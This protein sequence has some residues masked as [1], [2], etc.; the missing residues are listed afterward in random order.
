MRYVLVRGLALF[1]MLSLVAC[2]GDGGA[3]ATTGD[4]ASDEGVDVAGPDGGDG[5]EGDGANEEA[6]GGSTTASTGGIGDDTAADT[7]A[8]TT[9]T[10]TTT[11][12]DGITDTD[13]SG[14][15]DTSDATETTE[16]AGATD[17]DESSCT[18]DCTGRACGYDGCGG[19]CGN[20]PVGSACDNAGR[21]GQCLPLPVDCSKLENKPGIDFCESST[22]R[23]K[24]VFTNMQ[25]CEAACASGGLDC[26]AA[27]EN[28][29]TACGPDTTRPALTCAGTGHGSDYCECVRPGACKPDCTGKLCGSDG[30]GGLCGACA[31]GEN[32]VSG[33]CQLAPSEDENCGTYPFSANTLYAERL[34]FGRK[35]TGGDP[36][37]LYRV[38]TL[39]ASGAGSLTQA[40]ESDEPYWIV[41]DVEGTIRYPRASDGTP[42]KVAVR[43]NKTVDGRGRAIKIANAAFSFDASKPGY[44][45]TKNVIFS[46]LEI[47][48]DN[49]Q[50]GIGD[51]I[52]I[53]GHANADPD[54]TDTRDLWFHHLDLHHGG[55]GAI[56]NRGG[57]NITISWIHVHDHTKVMLHTK[58]TDNNAAPHQRIT[59]HHNWFD[60]TTRRGPQFAYG[61]ADFFNNWQDNWYEYGAASIDG[62]Q[63]LSE[64]NIYEARPGTVCILGC[65]DPSPHGGGNDFQVSKK[66]LVND[67]APD[68]TNGYTTSIG[69]LKINNAAVTV[70]S[71]EKVFDRKTYYSA[72]VDIADLNLK[73]RLTT[74]TGPRTTYCK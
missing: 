36:T 43:S 56:D 28:L 32:C 17:G 40:L 12:T 42:T 24:I 37:K 5:G 41:F 48:I 65:P 13:V 11:T 72:T 9:T 15:T 22:D 8:G 73:Q 20:C 7:S 50:D 4:P 25:G 44:P 59:Y 39:N 1:A 69:D 10:T 58:D 23:C 16:T 2:A 29:D 34:G 33:V 71:P 35:V 68:K 49:P 31:G 60:H 27:Y 61:L 63:F 70:A 64:A 19:S 30:C 53:R 55:D 6:G 38:T 67:W 45:G 52:G 21:T 18:P 3:A 47:F 74:Y 54:Q 26:V 46:D 57:T 14:T 62:A 66:G 51:L